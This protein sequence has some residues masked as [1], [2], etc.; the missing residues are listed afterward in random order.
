MTEHPGTESP[1]TGTPE[2]VD[3]PATATMV[4]TAHDLPID[5]MAPFFDESFT[6]IGA[7][8]S[9]QAVE[10]TGAA[11]SRHFRPMTTSAD[12]EVGFPVA[13]PIHP[14]A[15]VEAGELPAI[16]VARLVHAGGYDGLPAAWE[17]LIAWIVEQGLTPHPSVGAW[18]VYLTEPTADMDPAELRTELN[19]ALAED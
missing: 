7:L 6:A 18:E 1:G 5:G 17:T 4:V 10:I 16:R 2:I 14:E 13:S 3:S 15:P 8:A 9:K 12:L 19:Y 11:F